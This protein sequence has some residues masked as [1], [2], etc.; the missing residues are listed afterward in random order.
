[1]TD[2]LSML[3]TTLY[4]VIAFIGSTSESE[5]IHFTTFVVYVYFTIKLFSCSVR[6]NIKKMSNTLTLEW[7]NRI[8]N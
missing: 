8:I 7:Y 3:T 2:L 1:M 5:P 6:R 4:E